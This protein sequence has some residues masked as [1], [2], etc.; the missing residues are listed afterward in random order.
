M[1]LAVITD[2]DGTL[3][4]S[5]TYA[6]EPARPAIEA[7]RVRGVPL[8]VCTSKTWAESSRLQQMLGL[9][10]PAVVE[11]GGGVHDGD[12]TV[13]LGIE[14]RV[15]LEAFT[16]MKS[17]CPSLRGFSDMDDSEVAKRTGLPLEIAALARRREFDEP[18]VV[19]EDGEA[20]PASVLEIAAAR[21]LLISRGGRFH[22]LHGGSDKG[23]GAREARR[24][25]EGRLGPL[26]VVAL[27]DSPSD[28]SFLAEA[29]IAVILPRPDGT[30]DPSLVSALPAALPAARHARAP[31]PAGWNAAVLQ[32]LAEA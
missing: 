32:V 30:L 21:G 23:R 7:L 2:L 27:G 3:L 31:G 1:T 10:G 16:E 8:V 4:D 18:F 25:L 11:N 26:R 20:P 5:T 24:R 14:Y 28:L 17:A 19:G 15:V 9:P 13:V 12:E 22:H 29:D 6:W